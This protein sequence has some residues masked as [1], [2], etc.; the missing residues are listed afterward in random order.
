MRS[1]SYKLLAV[2]LDGTLLDHTGEPHAEDLEALRALH[3]AG[4]HVSIITGRLYAGTR[5]AATSI[6]LGG[7]VG[8]ADGSHVVSAD[9]HTTLAHHGITGHAAKFVSASLARHGPA[10]FVF[11]Q[12]T[13]VHD[14]M[15]EDFL[16]YVSTWSTELERAG[17]VH[18]HPSWEHEHGVTA[19]V[20]L[21]TEHQIAGAAGEIMSQ[22]GELAQTAMFPI[23]R[24]PGFYGLVVRAHG[25][26]K[27]TALAWIARHHGIDIRDTVCVGDWL[28]DLPMLAAAGRSFAMGQSPAEVKQAASDVLE[29]TSATG[30]GIARIVRE[31]F[32]VRA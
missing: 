20:A 30:G 3:R 22:L 29:E 31:V 18:D 25:Y 19:V 11:S 13:I 6:G 5:R 10:T 1:P 23:R 2:D 4:G 9:D 17:T 21:G 32:G 28:N 8:C 12:H 24:V 15:G 7:P 14:S 16:P 26:T 27:G